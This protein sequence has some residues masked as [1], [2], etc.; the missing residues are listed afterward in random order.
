MG[1]RDTAALRGKHRQAQASTGKHR[2]AAKHLFYLQLVY[3]AES[4]P[5]LANGWEL[6]RF[7]QNSGLGGKLVSV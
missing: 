1:H 7:C 4:V 5:A 3:Q 2:Q 6:Y